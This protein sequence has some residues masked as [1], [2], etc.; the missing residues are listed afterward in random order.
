MLT[1]LGVESGST[2]CP[3][4][5]RCCASHPF[6]DARQEPPVVTITSSLSHE[7]SFQAAATLVDAA[8]AMVDTPICRGYRAGWT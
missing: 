5:T 6:R 8:R 4:P 3:G 7:R 1:T 2:S